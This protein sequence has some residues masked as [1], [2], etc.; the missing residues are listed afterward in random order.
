MGRRRRFVVGR[1]AVNWRQ[2]DSLM[3]FPAVIKVSMK[4]RIF[5][6]RLEVAAIFILTLASLHSARAQGTAFTYDGRLLVNSAPATGN[7]D[8]Q[9]KLH[10]QSGGT[11]QIGSTLSL[12]P[13]GVT[14][15]LFT[16]AL[17]FGNVFNGTLMS[18]EVDVR[19]NGSSSDY[20]ALL[21]YQPINSVPYAVRAL[22]AA[23]Y[24][25]AIVDTQL[26][27]NVVTFSSG[28]GFTGPVVFSNAS[29]NFNGAFSGTFD[30][31]ATGSFTGSAT[32]TFTGTNIG[33]F[34]GNG[35][36]VTNVNVTNVVGVVQSNPNWQIIQATNQTL[37]A[38]NNY[39]ATNAALTTLTLPGNAGV[40]TTTYI[41]GSGANGWTVV[42]ATGQSILTATIGLPAG[43][44]WTAQTSA[45]GNGGWKAV[46]SSAD[47]MRL[48][49][50]NGTSPT[51]IYC[52]TNG[53]QTWFNNAPAGLSWVGIACS[54][55]GT[56]LVA[57]P[58]SGYPYTSANGGVSW[59]Q[60]TGGTSTAYSGVASSGDGVNLVAISSAHIYTSSNGGT[61]WTQRSNAGTGWT[62][63]ACSSDGTR[64]VAVA[65][66]SAKI[67]VSKDSGITWTSN[68]P[69]TSA[70]TCVAS[71]AD[72]TKLIAG[73]TSPANLYTSGDGGVTWTPRPSANGS[74]AN[75]AWKSVASSADGENLAAVS[76]TGFIVT[77][78]DGGQTWITRTNGIST[79][80]QPWTCI[81][82]SATGS[83]LLAG[84]NSGY[85]YT[86]VA[87][88]SPTN[89][90]LSGTQ[91]SSV[92][93][94]FIG[95]GQWMPLRFNG[96]FTG[97]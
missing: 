4:R 71:S 52:S 1:R 13:V 19:T 91:Y 16:V 36:G 7:F 21:P 23:A 74:L 9:F 63:V 72:G 87:A 56:R 97:K 51:A 41:S 45:V 79:V 11:N 17:D 20:T 28:G 75:P 90:S 40:G 66:A 38:S 33:T 8:M 60:Q 93:L 62:G 31:S 82:S 59:V 67:Y 39:L 76:N 24:T 54:T 14:N 61:N 44:I 53:G 89:G 58:S 27:T 81:A 50:A 30:G 68:G 80:Q 10:P 18:L 84:I 47:G 26:S 35:A 55:D 83:R 2:C 77:S 88:T 3:Q 94:Q 22:N 85:L 32:G 48:A 57:V 29:G 6:G 78:S 37:V 12:S 5:L 43:Q 73:S 46:A 96:S 69:P 25:G 70:F 86:S 34:I 65:N 95:N 42:P 92:E 49:A 15:G 64:I